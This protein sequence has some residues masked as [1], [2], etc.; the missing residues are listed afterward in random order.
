MSFRRGNKSRLVSKKEP[1]SICYED[2][3]S[4]NHFFSTGRIVRKLKEKAAGNEKGPSCD[5]LF[6]GTPVS[7]SALEIFCTGIELETVLITS[8]FSR[9]TDRS[10]RRRII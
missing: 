6:R 7:Y 10:I 3:A 8:L 4:R 5:D 1:Q 2:T 9:I